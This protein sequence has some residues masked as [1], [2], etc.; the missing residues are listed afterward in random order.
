MKSYTFS[1]IMWMLLCI[2][3]YIITF[4][5]ICGLLQLIFTDKA[6]FG[7]VTDILAVA[8]NCFLVFFAYTTYN[9]WKSDKTVEELKKLVFASY[10]IYHTTTQFYDSLNLILKN[11]EKPILIDGKKLNVTK[12]ILTLE[13]Y[14][15]AIKK[16]HSDFS[17]MIDFFVYF[18]PKD[19]KKLFRLRAQATSIM[20]RVNSDL[21]QISEIEID[22]KKID[23]EENSTFLD[24]I[25]K[26]KL[27]NESKFSLADFRND[28]DEKTKS[29]FNLKL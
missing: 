29:I 25:V 9:N 20:L 8:C 3:I 28:F 26:V 6:N 1:E 7:S 16:H 14:N 27:F 21:S 24:E 19:E 17:K 22:I 12:T 18:K 10:S 5:V 15:E 11:K 2:I 13:S 4:L 23:V